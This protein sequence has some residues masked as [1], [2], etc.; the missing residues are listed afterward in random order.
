MD[1]GGDDDGDDDDDELPYVNH[2]HM[3]GNSQSATEEMSIPGRKT[4][5][6]RTAFTDH[7]LSVLELSFDRRKYLSVHERNDLATRLQLTETQVKTWYQNRRFDS[8]I[9]ATDNENKNDFY[10]RRNSLLFRR[11]YMP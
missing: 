7:Q 2:M 4:R 5:R 10:S 6:A 3:T 8:N 1:D 11:L 9:S